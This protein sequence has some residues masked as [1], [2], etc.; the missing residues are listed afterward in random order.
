MAP[1]HH[2]TSDSGVGRGR[3]SPSHQ[4]EIIGDA[5]FRPY[6]VDEAAWAAAM[7]AAARMDAK[8]LHRRA[9]RMRL[10]L[11]GPQPKYMAPVVE[12]DEPSD[13][14]SELE[15]IKEKRLKKNRLKALQR[16]IKKLEEEL[17]K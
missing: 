4:G 17:N 1:A 14:P 5:G 11:D 15:A 8:G 12:A 9:W 7:Q 10:N 3:F 16:R 2:K 13:E 6:F